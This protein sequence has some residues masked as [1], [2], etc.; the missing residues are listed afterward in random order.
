[1]GFPCVDA[2]EVSSPYRGVSGYMILEDL[3]PYLIVPAVPVRIL[4]RQ[5]KIL[6]NKRIPLLRVLWD[7]SGSTEETCEPKAKMKL[8]FMKWFEE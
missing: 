3:R 8:K 4:E 1:M 2:E 5:D 6:R 7:Y